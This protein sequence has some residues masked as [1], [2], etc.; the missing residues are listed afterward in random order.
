MNNLTDDEIRILILKRFPRTFEI[1]PAGDE[2]IEHQETRGR[3][4]SFWHRL[5][6]EYVKQRETEGITRDEA[7]RE[8]QKQLVT[9]FNYNVST[10]T[11]M[12]AVRST[13]GRPYKDVANKKFVFSVL[14]NDLDQAVHWFKHLSPKE[15]RR[16]G[17]E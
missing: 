13:Y 12:N 1:G 3:R 7:C 2:I 14:Q 5:A 4:P 8:F 16:W 17:F 6:V 10:K 11:V 15:R 9:E